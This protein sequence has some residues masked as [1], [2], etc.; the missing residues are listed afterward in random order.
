MVVA[1]AGPLP[2]PIK[3]VVTACPAVPLPNPAVV[4][5]DTCPAPD[6]GV[7]AVRNSVAASSSPP[8]W[9]LIVGAFGLLP[10]AKSC[11]DKTVAYMLTPLLNNKFPSKFPGDPA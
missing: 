3:V 1:V 2:V 6:V 4:P 10:Q 11:P 9:S 5:K 7:A 8:A